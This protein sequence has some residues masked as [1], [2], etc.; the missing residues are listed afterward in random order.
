MAVRRPDI[1]NIKVSLR[2][3]AYK[4]MRRKIINLYLKESELRHLAGKE[5]LKREGSFFVLRELDCKGVFVIFYSG[6]VNITRLTT[7]NEAKL[8]CAAICRRLSIVAPPPYTIDSIQASG[9]LNLGIS[10]KKLKSVCD[11]LSRRR[12]E[13][14]IQSVNFNAE[15][16]PGAFV[17]SGKERGTALIFNSGKFV[18]VG[19]KSTSSVNAL[20]DWLELAIW[21]VACTEEGEE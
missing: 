17:R 7:L 2:L 6:H 12:Q 10:V 20:H 15:K 21:R 11:A 14:S 5:S 16:F 13:C 4:D 19:A 9:R 18:L 1:H 3:S 8:A